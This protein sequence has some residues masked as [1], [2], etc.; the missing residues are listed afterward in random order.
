MVVLVVSDGD[1]IPIDLL[2]VLCLF[3]LTIDSLYWL[4]GDIL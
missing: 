4:V 2:N 1:D 3:L